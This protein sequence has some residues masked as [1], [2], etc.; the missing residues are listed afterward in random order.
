MVPLTPVPTEFA[1]RVLVAKLGSAGIIAE[2]RGISQVYP[3]MFGRPEVWVEA[4]EESEARE[5][6]STDTEDVLDAAPGGE[7]MPGGETTP[8]VET[9]SGGDT[10]PG[11]GR[12]TPLGS[13]ARVILAAIALVLLVGVTLGGRGCSASTPQNTSHSR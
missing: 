1:G 13:P 12:R 10:M 9:T 6:I 5:L 2:L 7:T 3:A 11:I 4:N 8:G